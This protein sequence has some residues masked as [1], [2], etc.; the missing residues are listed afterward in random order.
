MICIYIDERNVM[1]D[2]VVFAAAAVWIQSDKI[3][4]WIIWSPFGLHSQA[5]TQTTL[6]FFTHYADEV[7]KVFKKI[8]V[9][10]ND[11]SSAAGRRHQH[12]KVL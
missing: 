11:Q 10:D 2:A 12:E 6:F 3:T 5:G 4:Y 8:G 1:I 9:D 7:P